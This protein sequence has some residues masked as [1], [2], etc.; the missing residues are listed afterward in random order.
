MSRSLWIAA[1]LLAVAATTQAQQNY[2]NQPIR[3]IVPWP[4]GGG[5]PGDFD[6]FVASEL[7]RYADVVK[8]SGA[9]VE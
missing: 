5:T 8:A 6:R 7:R 9:K 1:A 4:P 3:L 2:P